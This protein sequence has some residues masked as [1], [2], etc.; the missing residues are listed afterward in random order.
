[1]LVVS[2]VVSACMTPGIGYQFEL[3]ELPL[4]LL[5]AQ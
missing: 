2:K 1:M 5:E 3:A 4:S